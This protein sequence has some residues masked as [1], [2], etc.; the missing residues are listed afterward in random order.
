MASKSSHHTS[1]TSHTSRTTVDHDTIRHWAESRGGHPSTVEGTEGDNEVGVLRIDFEANGKEPHLR[2]IDWE[3]F[4]EKFDEKRL[5]FLYQEETSEGKESRFF[6][7][8]TRESA[9]LESRH[10]SESTEPFETSESTPFA[11]QDLALQL[12]GILDAEL[13]V[14][15]LFTKVVDQTSDESMRRKLIENCGIIEDQ[16]FE[17]ESLIYGCGGEPTALPNIEG[18]QDRPGPS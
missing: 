16:I 7:F 12:N 14:L 8:V 1:Q 15:D 18:T 2:E 9:E 11:D 3:K 4:F 13:T 5:A 6:K 17:I 10:E